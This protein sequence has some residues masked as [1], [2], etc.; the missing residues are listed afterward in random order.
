MASKRHSALPGSSVHTPVAFTYSTSALRL[1]ASSLTSEDVGKMAWQT[2]EDSFWLLKNHSPVTWIPV[3]GSSSGASGWLGAMA[4]RPSTTGFTGG[5]T[6]FNTTSKALETWSGDKW[7][8]NGVATLDGVEYLL[9]AGGG[10]GLEFGGGGGAGGYK[11]GI[12][13]SVTP[14]NYPV[15]IGAGGNNS[16]G[17]DSSFYSLTAIGGGKSGN[18]YGALPS[19]GGSGGGGSWNFSGPSLM[20][21]AQGTSGQGY[22]GGTGI[23]NA[24]THGHP[25]SGGGGGAGGSG[26]NAFVSAAVGAGIGGTGLLGFDGIRVCGGG[27]GFHY[28]HGGA[29]AV[30]G[31]GAGATGHYVPGTSGAA[32]KGGGGGGCGSDITTSSGGSGKLVLRY[33]GTPKATGGTITQNGGYTYHTFTGSGSFV[34]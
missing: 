14:G 12:L 1:A 23:S 33:E 26:G 3:G 21:P 15:L 16:N 2:D 10:A 19:I 5:E 13:A 7:F 31:G 27:G 28:D 20:A 9:I 4:S 25:G 34:V 6:I 22:A 32:N 8:T 29:S 18:K 11:T 17:S 30:D 24:C